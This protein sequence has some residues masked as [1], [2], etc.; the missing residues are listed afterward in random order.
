MPAYPASRRDYWRGLGSNAEQNSMHDLMVL[1]A[2][3][4]PVY[5]LAPEPANATYR[6]AFSMV[7]ATWKHRILRKGFIIPSFGS[8]DEDHVKRMNVMEVDIYDEDVLLD[9]DDYI[10]RDWG[11]FICINNVNNSTGIQSGAPLM[12][13]G[14]I[15]GIGCFAIEKG[16]EKVL[17]FTDVRDYV[18][19][20]YYCYKPHEQRQW[21]SR[22]WE[23]RNAS[24]YP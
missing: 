13:R 3:S 9:C 14:M 16:E 10:P 6:H 11:R 23:H 24:S 18:S 8:I 7:L 21:R 20:L 2:R 1:Y 17:V 5:N 4:P 19:N 22:Y 15:Y 12:H